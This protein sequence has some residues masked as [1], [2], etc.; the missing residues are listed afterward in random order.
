MSNYWF[1]IMTFKNFNKN[2]LKKFRTFCNKNK[3][4]I[5]QVW[6]PAHTHKYLNN[7]QT[8]KTNNSFKLYQN[9]FC[10]PSSLNLEKK[11]LVF[12]TN[13]IKDFCKKNLV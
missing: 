9:S 1:N 10:L 3:I 7:F 8:Y 12:I 5:R 2:K 4:E 11:N 6:R 13:K